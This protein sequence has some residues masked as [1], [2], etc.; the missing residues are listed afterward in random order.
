MRE[1]ENAELNKRVEEEARKLAAKT[2][3][4]REKAF[5]RFKAEQERKKLF[6]LAVLEDEWTQDQQNCFENALLEYPASVEKHE[7]WQQISQRVNGKNKQ[8]CLAR[9]RFLKE[10]ILAGKHQSKD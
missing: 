8:Q 3:R 1:E 5:Q 4:K 2:A 7:R 9:Y 6:E 10:Y